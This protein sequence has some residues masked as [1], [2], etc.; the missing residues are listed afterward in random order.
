[1][2]RVV[3]CKSIRAWVSGNAKEYEGKYKAKPKGNAKDIFSYKANY[4]GNAKG[5]SGNTKEL[6]RIFEEIQSKHKGHSKDFVT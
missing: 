4:R 6:E 5:F 1:M 3:V 2:A